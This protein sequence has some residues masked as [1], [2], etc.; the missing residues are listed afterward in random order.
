MHVAARDGVVE[1]LAQLV[2]ALTG[3]VDLG[4]QVIGL[5]IDHRTEIADS[6]AGLLGTMLVRVAHVIPGVVSDIGSHGAGLSTRARG[7]SNADDGTGGGAEERTRDEVES[8]TH[9]HSSPAGT[10]A[11]TV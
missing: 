3:Q 6:G 1:L 5:G 8:L 4:A 10:L 9:D 2:H 7:Q 11:P